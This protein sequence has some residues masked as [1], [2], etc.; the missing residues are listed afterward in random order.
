MSNPGENPQLQFPSQLTP[1]QFQQLME[2]AAQQF[3]Q[4]DPQQTAEMT[5]DMAAQYEAMRKL[6]AAARSS[7]TAN[8][9]FAAIQAQKVVDMAPAVRPP[10]PQQ[11]MPLANLLAPLLRFQK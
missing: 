3:Q 11:R 9:H 4:I 5:P 8:P 1:E 6:L 7:Q 10:T 2:L